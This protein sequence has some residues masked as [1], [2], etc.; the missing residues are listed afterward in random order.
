MGGGGGWGVTRNW[1]RLSKEKLP[2]LCSSQDIIRMVKSKRA[3]FTYSGEKKCIRSFVG[4]TLKK[5]IT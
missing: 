2:D 4:E 3:Y 5:K 1:T